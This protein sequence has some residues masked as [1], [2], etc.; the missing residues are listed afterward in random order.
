MEGPEGR[1]YKVSGAR[2]RARVASVREVL[3]AVAAG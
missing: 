2:Q 3:R 1:R